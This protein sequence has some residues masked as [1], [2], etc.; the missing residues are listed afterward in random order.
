M[1]EVFIKD[2][3]LSNKKKCSLDSEIVDKINIQHNKGK[4][5]ARERI[6]VLLDDGSFEEIGPFVEHSCT[7][8]NMEKKKYYGDGVIVGYGTI[9]G[10]LVFVY[11]QD[12]TILGGSLGEAH[13]KKICDLIDKAI[14]VGAP[15]IG[16]NDSGGARIQE[17]VSSLSAYGS[18][19][20]KNVVASGVIPQISLI[21]GPCA[22]GA[23]YSPA[24]TDFIFMVQ[25]TSYMFV[26]GPN[27]VNTI[28]GEKCDNESL[29]GSNVH[30]N[31]GVVDHVFANDIEALL[32]TRRFINFL[33]LSNTKK[34]PI[35]YT[36]DTG[37]R[38][39]M[40]L[41]TIIPNDP[42]KPYNMKNLVKIISDEN[43]FFEIQSNFAQNIIVG[44]SYM[45]GCPVGIV[46]NQ[47]MFLSGALD[48]NASRKAARFV[49]FCDAFNIPIITLVDVPGF[50]PGVAQEKGG[51]IKHGAKLIYA[52]SEATVP[53]IT[54]ITRKA[55][56]GAYIVMGSKHLMGDINYAWQESK[57]SVMGA[58]S[59][60]K[61]IFNKIK[62]EKEIKK[63]ELEYEEKITS[64]FIAASKGYIDDIIY[65]SHTRL[66]ICQ[67][68]NFLKTKK[69]T[70]PWKKHDN[71]PL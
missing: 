51:I 37:D 52:Y 10:R 18:I 33:P 42:N 17:G 69:Q 55:Y 44:F 30:K 20:Q 3:N 57:I 46:A 7:S 49:R 58:K 9:S 70:L 50:L 34:L 31:N 16:I 23:V 54:V 61:V 71:I 21:M 56:G 24:I 39:H 14:L 26:T 28:S 15:V 22:G 60:I 40:S 67:A 68:L 65:P 36:K 8:F 6:E 4:L 11:S 25:K 29:G 66:R 47:P 35:R 62:D 48:I 32:E 5:T 53:K 43:E 59:A 13:G 27:V 45:E 63:K 38:V 64:A 1:S 41:N 2:N 12:F 19:F